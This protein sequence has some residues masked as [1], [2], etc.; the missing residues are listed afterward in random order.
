MFTLLHVILIT[1]IAAVFFR[2]SSTL[3]VAHLFFSLGLWVSGKNSRKQ[4][5]LCGQRRWII[6]S[7]LYI[8]QK[9]TGYRNTY[10]PTLY[11]FPL[12]KLTFFTQVCEIIF[13]TN[14]FLGF[15]IIEFSDLQ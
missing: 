13:D 15:V 14:T 7:G 9:W 1:R 6:T 8:L 11:I 10:R 3:F 4:N 12:K 5:N 2:V